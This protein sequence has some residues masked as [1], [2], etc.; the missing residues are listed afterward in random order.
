MSGEKLIVVE[1]ESIGLFSR[2]RIESK[3]R[4]DPKDIQ[5]AYDRNVEALDA[6][7]AARITRKTRKSDTG[8]VT[9]VVTEEGGSPDWPVRLDAAK[10]LFAMA[11]LKDAPDKPEPPREINLTI[12]TGDQHVTNQGAIEVRASEST[13]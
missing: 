13:A 11:G 6:T 9:E 10:T 4:F 1:T 7:R 8:K 12:V 5:R 2:Q 3:V